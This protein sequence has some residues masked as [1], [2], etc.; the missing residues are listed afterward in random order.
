MPGIIFDLG[1]KQI[2]VFCCE[3]LT[4][5]VYRQYAS[6]PFQLSDKLDIITKRKKDRIEF[7]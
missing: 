1:D 4:G 5:C 6:V 2:N 3:E 7:D